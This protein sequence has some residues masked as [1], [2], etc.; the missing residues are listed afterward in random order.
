[1]HQRG[2]D[3][4]AKR[5]TS[6]DVERKADLSPKDHLDGADQVRRQMHDADLAT[7]RSLIA[8]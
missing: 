4:A 6:D 5:M 8:L 3:S 1:M 7:S 2:R